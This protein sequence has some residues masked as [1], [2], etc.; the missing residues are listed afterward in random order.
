MITINIFKKTFRFDVTTQSEGGKQMK[1]HNYDIAVI[2]GGAAGLTA[3][4]TAAGFNKKTAL[5]EK[6]RLGGECTWNGCVPSKALLKSA[7][8]AH[9]IQHS[10]KYGVKTDNKID[11]E[12]VM[13]YVHSVQQKVY[14]EEN[15]AVLE[16]KGIDFFNS[17]AEFADSSTLRAGSSLITADKIIIASG[18]SPFIPDIA[19]IDDISYLTNESLFKINSLPESMIIIGGGP[20]GVEMAQ[21]FNRLGVEVSLVQRSGRILKKEE[22]EFSSLLADRL[23]SEGINLLT[24]FEALKIEEKSEINLTAGDK[25][26]NKKLLKA[27]K[28]LI[29]AGR[30]PNIKGFN[31]DK[32]GIKT[33]RLGIVTDKKMRTNI[34]SIYA[35]GDVVGPYRFSHISYHEA[36]TAAVNAVSPIA[37]KNMDYENIIW[38]T[39]TDPE[40]AHLALTEAEAREKYGDKIKVY[41]L[42]YSD[43]DRA[44]TESSKGM[45]KFICDKR[46]K[47][48][49]AHIIGERAGEIIHSCQI[50]KSLDL[51]FKKL[52]SVIHAY[53]SYAEIVRDG[54][55]EAYRGDWEKKL[56]FLKRFSF[57]NK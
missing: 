30:K 53:P 15:P 2:G 4:F 21:A 6:E 3:A 35:A 55:K 16:K 12:E 26:G 46:G 54:A 5:I 19:G 48:L 22:A 20:I 36:L 57:N 37:F 51:P 23:E 42:D 43:L 29:A 17:H 49:G 25:K 56:E 47:L 44:I 50:L 38:T 27:E 52:Q 31:L 41:E 33:S 32:L 45:A 14:Q 28:I 8:T 11:N 34:S 39:Y 9:Y 18:S 40:L 13:D 1:S 24:G 10:E 7:K